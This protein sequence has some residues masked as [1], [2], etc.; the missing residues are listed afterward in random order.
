MCLGAAAAVVAGSSKKL[1][2]TVSMTT[3]IKQ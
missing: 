1:N 2:V 3:D